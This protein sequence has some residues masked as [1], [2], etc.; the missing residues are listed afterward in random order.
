MS[1]NEATKAVWSSVL[2]RHKDNIHEQ[3]GDAITSVLLHALTKMS[4]D[5]M[6]GI[7]ICLDN[8]EQ[9]AFG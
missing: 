6:S 8:M 5:C 1:N 2:S 7:L 3:T 9:T 4:S